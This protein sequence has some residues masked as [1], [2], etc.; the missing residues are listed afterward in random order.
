MLKQ[1]I[2]LTKPRWENIAQTKGVIYD[3]DTD[4]IKEV[5]PVLGKP[6]ELREVLVN[7]INNALETMRNGD[8]LSFRT[9]EEDDT[10]FVS[11]S[12]TGEGMDEDVQKNV[13]DPFFTTRSPIGKGLGLSISYGIITRH[14]GKIDVESEVGK[15][16]T[17]TIRL[18]RTMNN[19]PKKQV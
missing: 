4:G 11:I 7:I 9:G 17:F 1:A 13:F 3:I 6:I 2:D 8:C 10:V 16:S 15:G 5:A 12:D 14:G 19:Q 18:P